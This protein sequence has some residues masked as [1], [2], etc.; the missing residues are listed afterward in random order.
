[1]H[2][3]DVRAVENP[4][5]AI[6]DLAEDVNERLPKI[7]KVVSYTRVF[8]S[9]WLVIDALVIV[10]LALPPLLGP[11][12]AVPL[13]LLVYLFLLLR[14]LTA[15]RAVRTILTALAIFTAAPLVLLL[16]IVPGLLLVGLFYL[17][18]VV[19]ELLA[20][21]RRF[22]EYYG[23]RH[24]VIRSVRDED[25]SV[26]IP[27]GN[28][29]VERLL[30]HLAMRSP[31]F[32]A[33]RREHVRVPASMRGFSGALHQFDALVGVPGSFWGPPGFAVIVRTFPRPPTREDLE[34]LKRA[35]EDACAALKTPPARVI[36]LWREGKDQAVDRAAYE[37]VTS[38]VVNYE[39]LGARHRCSLEVISESPDGTYD[40]VPFISDTAF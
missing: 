10:L 11:I 22:L 35:A 21:L 6:F 18:M 31:R 29:P 14:R 25:P 37:Y 36:G 1:M 15:D 2:R 19:L 38:E 5:S 8:V 13:L 30:A 20:D 9:V 39:R 33:V 34:A 12:L 27:A 28:T 40:F 3:G 26:R 32:R 7:R 23:L 17:G 16:A 24:R 4:I